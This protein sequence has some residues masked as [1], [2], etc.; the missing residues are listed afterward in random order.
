ML[1]VD[2]DVKNGWHKPVIQPYG[3]FPISPAATGLHYGIQV[4][5]TMAII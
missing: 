5:Q 3:D 4:L 1:V 2:W